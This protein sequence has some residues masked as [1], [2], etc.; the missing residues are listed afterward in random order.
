[1]VLT[2]RLGALAIDFFGGS[3]AIFFSDLTDLTAGINP[4]KQ[5][6]I[7]FNIIFYML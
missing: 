2:T 4:Q 6:D 5:A 3:D 7:F 1:L